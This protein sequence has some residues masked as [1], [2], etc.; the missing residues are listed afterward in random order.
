MSEEKEMLRDYAPY[1]YLPDR[2][3]SLIVLRDKFLQ[4]NGLFK[5]E[6]DELSSLKGR[7]GYEERRLQV[8]ERWG[9]FGDEKEFRSEH[10]FIVRV[11]DLHRQSEDE[12]CSSY[13]LTL[14]INLRWPTSKI[15]ESL[16][17]T[18]KHYHD[19]YHDPDRLERD[20][21][22]HFREA[23]PEDRIPKNKQ[24]GNVP[25]DLDEYTRNLKAYDMRIE[26]R[27]WAQ[28][29]SALDITVDSARNYY[30]AAARI[31]KQG[32]PGFPPFP[33]KTDW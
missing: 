33:P 25:K 5:Q 21:E 18:L 24:S 30:Y 14:D 23:T 4:R 10:P 19:L 28:I 2:L 11:L 32:M 9:I 16:A 12:D 13:M 20:I 8:C 6:M 1:C 15:T 7:E 26:G 17:S 22:H 27:S 29:A 31:V 3:L